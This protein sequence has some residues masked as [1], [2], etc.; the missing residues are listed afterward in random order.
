MLQARDGRLWEAATGE[1][2][3]PD[4]LWVLLVLRFL[5]FVLTAG[6]PQVKEEGLVVLL[7]LPFL[8]ASL[9]LSLVI[10]QQVR[11]IVAAA[12][13]HHHC[14]NGAGV[15]VLDLEEALDHIDVLRFH[16]LFGEAKG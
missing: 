10:Q 5:V 1:A 9:R 3:T 7:L 11:V 8:P 14:A 2:V 15:D 13:R 12:V 4:F 6:G 16:V